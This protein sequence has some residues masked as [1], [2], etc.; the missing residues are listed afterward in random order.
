M[1]GKSFEIKVSDLLNH[2]GSDSVAFEEKSSALLPQLTKEGMS[3]VLFFRS[4]DEESI[5]VSL[6]DFDCVLEE[7]CDS[8]GTQFLRPLHV[9]QYQAKCTLNPKELEES[10]DEVLFLID[11][12]KET[13]DV[14]DML[15]QAVLLQ[16]PFVKRC[17]ACEAALQDMPSEEVSEGRN[18]LGE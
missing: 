1:K 10:T 2:L 17:P 14:E 13:I 7:E 15:Y 11:P 6:E 4:V 9:D 12:K 16:E 8:C 3:G 5:L 18:D